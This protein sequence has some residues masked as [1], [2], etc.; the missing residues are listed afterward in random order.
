VT[1]PVT[2]QS[3]FSRVLKCESTDSRTIERQ[4]SVCAAYSVF[5]LG[6]CMSLMCD[7]QHG[8]PDHLIAPFCKILEFK[9]TAT[10]HFE[11]A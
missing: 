8:A 7:T 2:F 6:A 9:E 11:C 3:S 5:Y 4:Q 10:V 1:L